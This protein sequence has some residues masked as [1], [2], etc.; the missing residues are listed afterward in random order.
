[1]LPAHDPG[2]SKTRTAPHLVPL[3]PTSVAILS[4]LEAPNREHSGCIF[5]GRP[6]DGSAASPTR[7]ILVAAK[8]DLD[9]RHLKFGEP[10]RIHDL[11]RTVRTGMSQLSVSPHIAELV[12]GHS[13]GGVVKVYDRY[14][15][16]EEKREALTRWADYLLTVVGE[17]PRSDNVIPIGEAKVS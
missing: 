10:W 2:R 6:R 17:R 16:V 11:R 7:A 13:I 14:D 5:K 15:Y 1:M 3:T 9:A 8:N 4:E 12:I